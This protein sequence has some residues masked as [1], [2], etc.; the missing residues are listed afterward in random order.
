M[1]SLKQYDQQAK[2]LL[3]QSNSENNNYNLF[4]KNRKKNEIL[5]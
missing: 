3:F 4:V 2:A 1:D 5:G